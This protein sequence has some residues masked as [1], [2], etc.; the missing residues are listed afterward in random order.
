MIDISCLD[1]DGKESS[2]NAFRAALA[3]GEY[4]ESG[5]KVIN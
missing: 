5:R 1:E 3:I 2:E 4:T